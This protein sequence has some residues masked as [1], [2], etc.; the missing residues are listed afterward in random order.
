[1]ISK[2]IQI[3]YE[4]GQ[5]DIDTICRKHGVD[6]SSLDWYV[7][8]TVPTVPE[9][10]ISMDIGKQLPTHIEI[11]PP[12]DTD[13]NEPKLK[14]I[15]DIRNLILEEAHNK[16]QEVK[17]GTLDMS[18]KEL[19]EVEALTTNIESSIKPKKDA[20]TNTINILVQNLMDK[21]QDDC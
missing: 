12:I 18:T 11:L 17:A 4:T 1:M 9:G 10:A 13:P 21:T 6:K 15:S 14:K 8:P 3:E 16:L 7:E 19:K 20:P 2:I 5:H